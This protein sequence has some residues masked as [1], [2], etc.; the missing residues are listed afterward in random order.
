MAKRRT[1][2]QKRQAKHQ[3]LLKWEPEKPI[4]KAKA[5]KTVSVPA[6]KGQIK[7]Q[8]DLNIK[9]KAKLK[10]ADFQ[11][12]N[13]GLA[14]IKRDLVK[15]LIIASLVLALEVVLYLAWK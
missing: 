3:F 9:A 5:R 7:N 6:V 4:A 13:G 12:N 15:S 1:K 10:I 14:S 11:A 2:K 8:A